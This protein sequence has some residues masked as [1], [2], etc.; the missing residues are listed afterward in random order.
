M[1]GADETMLHVFED[2]SREKHG[3]LRHETDLRSEPLQVQVMNVDTIQAHRA[4]ERII[5]P[6]D[7][8]DDGRFARSRSTYER[9]RL[10]CW[11]RKAEVLDDLDVRARRVI[12]VN[13]LEGNF[14]NDFARLKAFFAGRINRRD[15]IYGGVELR[16]CPT[17]LGNSYETKRSARPARPFKISPYPEFRELLSQGRKIQ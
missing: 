5:E 17:S 10:A 13:I 14:A 8:R 3:L 6:F 7:K 12:E 11:E 1:R 9:C 16:G 2:G 4:S 15:T